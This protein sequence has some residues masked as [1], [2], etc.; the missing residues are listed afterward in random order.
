M[1]DDEA[2][3]SRGLVH[4]KGL[5]CVQGRDSKTETF[6]AVVMSGFLL[7]SSRMSQRRGAAEL[8]RLMSSNWRRTTGNIGEYGVQVLQ[9]R[10]DASVADF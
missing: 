8:G 7:C 5:Q 3:C 1:P 10:N 2:C 9:N 4:V 6:A